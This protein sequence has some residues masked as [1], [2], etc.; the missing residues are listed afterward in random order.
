[1]EYLLLKLMRKKI[2]VLLL[3]LLTIFG[4]L[5][6]TSCTHNPMGYFPE[7]LWDEFE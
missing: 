6:L 5:S 7:G 3:I 2:I 4:S 1:M